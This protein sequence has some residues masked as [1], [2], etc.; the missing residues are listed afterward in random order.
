MTD[1]ESPAPDSTS[2]PLDAEAEPKSVPAEEPASPAKSAADKKKK[3]KAPQPVLVWLGI[4]CL[5]IGAFVG[6]RAAD[7]KSKYR[8]IANRLNDPVILGSQALKDW[9]AI[10]RSSGGPTC[11]AVVVMLTEERLPD[12]LQARGIA[13]IEDLSI[14]MAE[15]GQLSSICEQELIGQLNMIA[16]VFALGGIGLILLDVLRE[17][18]MLGGGKPHAKD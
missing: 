1:S 13:S 3:E 6:W 18:G 11:E 12:A 9:S 15:G 14:A 17:R 10:L 5:L 8:T 7:R 16:W 4:A 2:Q